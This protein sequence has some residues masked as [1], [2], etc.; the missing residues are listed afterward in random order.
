MRPADSQIASQVLVAGHLVLGQVHL[1]ADGI[2]EELERAALVVEGVEND[3]D[4]V[5]VEGGIAIGVAGADAG[6]LGIVCTEGNVEVV[7]VELHPAF[8]THRRRTILRGTRF[9]GE[10]EG[11]RGLPGRV[12]EVAVDAHRP[13]EP[14]RAIALPLPLLGGGH[15]HGEKEHGQQRGKTRQ[16]TVRQ[17]HERFLLAWCMHSSSSTHASVRSSPRA[18]WNVMDDGS[19]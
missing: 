18:A 13:F 12:V 6:G 10:L 17:G 9:V 15:L 2:D 7:A 8:G 19:A 1:H 11:R 3:A 5:V 4:E 16:A 14:F